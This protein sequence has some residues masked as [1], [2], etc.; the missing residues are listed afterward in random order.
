MLRRNFLKSIVG[1][2]IGAVALPSAVKAKSRPKAFCWTSVMSAPGSTEWSK[3]YD[4]ELVEYRTWDRNLSRKEIDEL[5]KEPYSM[6][7]DSLNT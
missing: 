7:Y 3:Y 4:G 1:V 2:S 5:Y 6:F